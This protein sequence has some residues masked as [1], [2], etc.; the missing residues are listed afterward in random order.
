MPPTTSAPSSN[1]IDVHQDRRLAALQLHHHR[2][3]STGTSRRSRD[4][5]K[6]TSRELA[7]RWCWRGCPCGGARS[8]RSGSRTGPAD[9]GRCTTTPSPTRGASSSS[10]SPRS[11]GNVPSAIMRARRSN[12]VEVLTLEL[13]GT[14]RDDGRGLAAHHRDR[15]RRGTAPARTG[16]A[17]APSSR[18]AGA[19]PDV[20]SA[21]CQVRATS[22]R[23]TSSTTRPTRS[24]G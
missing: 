24:S 7:A 1:G 6:P 21:R 10:T 22:G 20:I 9:R 14:A 15:S 17:P 13:A 3:A 11:N 19:M 18:G 4:W 16:G 2:R 5:S 23:S 8:P 12:D